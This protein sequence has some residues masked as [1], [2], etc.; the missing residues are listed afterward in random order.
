MFMNGVA[1]GMAI[2]AVVRRQIRV[3]AL[4]ASSA[5]D[6]VTTP[7]GPCACRFVTTTIAT[8]AKSIWASALP[9]VQNN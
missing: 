5:A 3:A 1:I 6:V 4:P 9:P 8:I 2:T 7:R